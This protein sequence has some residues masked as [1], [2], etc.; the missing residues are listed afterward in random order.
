MENEK[1]IKEIG[2]LIEAVNSLKKQGKRVVHCHGCFD[3]IH[4]GHIR[5]LKFAKEQGDVLVVSITGDDFVGKSYMNPFATQSLR[6]Q[7]LSSIEYV[8]L[9][10]VNN[11]PV[12]T[13]LI[14]Q[15]KPDVYIKG[16]EYAKDKKVHPGFVEEKELVES[17]GG[18]IV[19]SPG[20]VIFS[21]TQIIKDLLQRQDVREEKIN[22][23]LQ[24]HSVS[25]EN[26]IGAVENFKAI[27]VLILG[28]IFFEDYIFVTKPKVSSSS[29][30][31]N[32]DFVEKKRFLGGAGL[33]AQH[34]QDM[35]AEFKI[36]GVGNWE[37]SK[38][39]DELNPAIQNRVELIKR[40]NCP[41]SIKKTFL[42][43]EQKILELSEK[44][45]VKIDEKTELEFIKKA[46]GML[47][48]F[49]AVIFCDYS[50]GFLNKNIVNSITEEAK[51]RSIIC[52]SIIDSEGFGN[53][54]NYRFLDFVVCSEK[55]ARHATNNFIDGI[56]FLARD[57]LQKTEY[58]HLIVNLGKEGLISYNPVRDP[59]Q[60]VS[61][62]A[63]YLPFFV[64]QVLDGAGTK[65]ILV[66]TILLS[67]ASGLDIY[68]SV[69]LG[70]CASSIAS[71]KVGSETASKEEIRS[72]L[73]SRNYASG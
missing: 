45:G 68:H 3:L 34:I 25:K 9:V 27:K 48:E 51:K 55:E 57:F 30:I 23:F 49:Q 4:P 7:S 52:T 73:E 69:Y 59:Q 33:V 61:T 62:Y 21:S 6:A 10:Y 54:L 70:N 37:I 63:G 36:L 47:D 42:S 16:Q 28:D 56:D 14:K 72:C 67:L 43:D 29:S 19:Y 17:L 50:Q 64:N 13:E 53:L 15:I 26:L 18:K 31:L 41:P 12:A 39:L 20:D 35:G 8:D 11:S 32:F 38:A 58:N 65:E 24:R 66:S 46:V 5:H 60:I 40:D 1:K 71:S 2:E 22:N 44:N